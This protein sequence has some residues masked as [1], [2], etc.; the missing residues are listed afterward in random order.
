MGG[1]RIAAP[2]DTDWT[3]LPSYIF[4]PPPPNDAHAALEAE[5]FAALTAI[6]AAAAAAASPP[7]P[8][9]DVAP[10][11][12]VGPPA[13][14]SLNDG[15]LPTYPEAPTDAPPAPRDYP[16]T[17]PGGVISPEVVPGDPGFTMPD[18][19]G[20]AP[21]WDP[22][23]EPYSPGAPV[24]QIGA[25]NTPAVVPE[26]P[27]DVIPLPTPGGGVMAILPGEL[28]F[29]TETPAPAPPGNPPVGLPP[30]PA[31][32]PGIPSGGW[33]WDE[34]AKRAARAVKDTATRK[35]IGRAIGRRLLGPIG[36]II[37]VLTPNQLGNDDWA[38]PSGPP[39][40][41]PSIGED[42]ARAGGI[43][44]LGTAI[45]VGV[46]IDELGNLPPAI[47]PL[48]DDELVGVVVPRV[49]I[50]A[51]VITQPEVPWPSPTPPTIPSPST[52][53]PSTPTASAPSPAATGAPA[54][55]SAPLPGGFSPSTIAPWSALLSAIIVSRNRQRTRSPWP[56]IFPPALTSS[57]LPSAPSPLQS[58][59]PVPSATLVPTTT[60]PGSTPLTAFQP[61]VSSS[62]PP[63]MRT[64]TRTRECHC[65]SKPK[66]RRKPRECTTRGQLVWASGPKK[67][68]PAGTRCVTFKGK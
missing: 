50:P 36:V 62:A 2:E 17:F 56:D 63:T 26:L 3:P 54:P 12:Y 39:A 20:S 38:T 10:T 29:P 27:G 14:P 1:P 22:T 43:I 60:A 25:P 68:K 59:L 5:A 28:T 13:P 44:G 9:A 48:G 45:G 15:P 34:Y 18:G 51:P 52:P 47:P 64:R 8:V 21:P 49:E 4:T 23:E 55:A 67:G 31:T 19:G 16:P 6:Q 40:P 66:K 42:I 41:E 33:S 58:A 57:P 7:P 65:D 37:D 11:P 53:A 35:G 30:G 32:R 46:I 24:P 61:A